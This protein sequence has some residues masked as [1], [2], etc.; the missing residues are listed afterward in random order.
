MIWAALLVATPALAEE[1]ITN[2][3]S[4]VHVQPDGALDVVET[5]G[6]VSEGA[7]IQRGIQRDFPTRY[8]GWLG[9]HVQVGFEVVD[10]ERDGHAEPY[11]LMEM[12]NG[13]RVRI[14]DADTMLP[15]GDHVYR[16]HYRTTR[17]LGFYSDFDELYWNVTGTGWT[18]PIERAEARISLPGAVPFGRRAVYTGPQGATGHDAVVISEQPGRITF[19]TTR[20]LEAE[21]GL[22]VA[23]AWRKGLVA[24]PGRLTRL[25]W[26]LR[27]NGVMLLSLAGLAAIL[28]HCALA[29]R[30]A[31][32]N[33]D[34]HVM[35]P[36]FAPPDDLSAAALR[37][38][39]RMGFDDR[40][41]ATAI[42][43]SAV[44]GRLRIVETSSGRR[45]D[46][47]IETTDGRAPLARPEEKMLAKLFGGRKSVA[48]KQANYAVLRDARGTLEEDLDT[49]YGEDR[50][51]TA[52]GRKTLHGAI[53]VFGLL[54]LVTMVTVTLDAATPLRSIAIGAVIM[55]AYAGMRWLWRARKAMGGWRRILAG[56]VGVGIGL[57]LLQLCVAL[58][59][60]A[61]LS[62]HPLPLVPPL[63]AIPFVILTWRRLVVPTAV[64][65]PLRDRIAG[66]RH[67]LAVAEEDRLEKLNP[68]EKTAALFER[69]L[70]YAMALGVENRWA[71]RFSDVLAAA[72]LDD[73]AID[74]DPWY[75]GKTPAWT[76]TSAFAAS[77]GSSLTSTIASAATAPGSSG[78]SSGSSG[79]S[80]SGSSGGGS[81]GGGGG[82]G[83]GSGW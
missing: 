40:T 8:P 70:P 3:V 49:L 39:W 60:M 74:R 44:R 25:G 81:S 33:P 69:F 56:I 48:L 29:L 16:I 30:R 55:I 2:F 47:K 31:R 67:Y 5:I 4:D 75:V 82:G 32:R 15:P 21:E 36:L 71:K 35:V 54:M 62:G 80:S 61:A 28:L 20:R 38:I 19:R 50:L 66:F 42:V 64:G 68:P 53:A 17:Q 78:G 6:L 46:R 59:M 26:W 83:G 43:D 63:L 18:F 27:E 34:A 58:I 13:Q 73:S 12:R 22:T 79:S 45:P 9:G 72:A 77:I 76:N 65:W 7:E 52:A 51:F 23:A 24:A 10:V 1:R 11:R 57:L 37:Y 14:G 41:F